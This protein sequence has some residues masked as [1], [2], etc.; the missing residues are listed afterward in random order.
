M[1]AATAMSLAEAGHFIHSGGHLLSL[2]AV[3][4]AI[5]PNRGSDDDRRDDEPSYLARKRVRRRFAARDVGFAAQRLMEL[6]VESLTG[7]SPRRTQ[8]WSGSTTA[9]A[10]AI[11]IGRPERA[12]SSCASPS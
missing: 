4:W 2:I 6:E 3:R 10:T 5:D 12:P 9:T 11:A 7:R 1:V 8:P